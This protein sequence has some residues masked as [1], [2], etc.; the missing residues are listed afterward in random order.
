[1]QLKDNKVFFLVFFAISCLTS[2]AQLLTPPQVG[3]ANQTSEL[4]DSSGLESAP[5]KTTQTIRSDPSA[6][7]SDKAVPVQT[8]PIQLTKQNYQQASSQ[9]I[10][11]LL[12]DDSIE[13]LLT[14]VRQNY[15]QP[16]AV[17]DRAQRRALVEGLF[18]RLGKG[19]RFIQTSELA[20]VKESEPLPFH[21]EILDEKIAYI[22]PSKLSRED[23]S[24]MDAVL[25]QFA[26]KK[27]LS[28]I[29]DLRSVGY[30]ADF[31]IAAEFARRFAPQGVVLF[32]M[33]KPSAKQERIFASSQSPLFNGKI[34]VLIDQ[35][36]GGAS[37]V[38]AGCLRE[39]A[40]AL[41]IGERTAGIAVEF[42]PLPLGETILLQ[43][44]SSEA[45]LPSGQKI[46]P[47]GINPDLELPQPN[48]EISLQLRKMASQGIAAVVEEKERPRFNE[49]ALANNTNPE[50]EEE[51]AG[52]I[53]VPIIDR[54]LQR[55]IDIAT[56]LN[57]LNK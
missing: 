56:A 43:V 3:Q 7:P 17:N 48:E 29:L 39:A 18:C 41:L 57:I 4:K 34:F 46:F 42:V 19:I 22:R 5:F 33:E 36:T 20:P 52:K 24:Q 32:R 9:E 54:T 10:V 13:K 25:G 15:V 44:A 31:E 38:L 12:S 55:A 21:A 37:E 23:L 2:F 50:L 40:F 27:V 51:V 28:L 11:S 6:Q 30:C 47:V 1:M 16:Q 45:V 35:R 26:D 8:D 49:S 53:V 14:F